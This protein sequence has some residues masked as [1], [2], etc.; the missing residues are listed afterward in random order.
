[1][2]NQIETIA[3]QLDADD[4]DDV[5]GGVTDGTSNMVI[6]RKA[7]GTQQDATTGAG[8]GIIAIL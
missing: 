4:L 7:G 2:I 5:T 8:A 6:C 1:M 3:D